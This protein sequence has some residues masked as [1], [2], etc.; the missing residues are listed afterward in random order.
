MY[1]ITAISASSD[2]PITPLSTVAIMCCLLLYKT[3][4]F[5]RVYK[6]WLLNSTEVFMYFNIAIFALITSYTVANPPSQNKEILH[7][8]FVYLSIGATAILFMII[9][10]YHT[11]RCGCSKFY[12]SDKITKFVRKIRYKDQS[13]HGSLSVNDILDAIDSPRARSGGAT[14]PTRTV[15]ALTNYEESTAVATPSSQ[16]ITTGEHSSSVVHSDQLEQDS[17]ESAVNAFRNFTS[18]SAR[19]TTQFQG[20]GKRAKP[21]LLYY[22]TEHYSKSITKPLLDDEDNL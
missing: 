11:Y 4:L 20:T 9:I 6:N 3:A 17:N 1:I 22:S 8:T 2:Q 7:I 16:P 19:E 12:S 5:I 15:V 10:A 14:V 21:K 18:K 13:D